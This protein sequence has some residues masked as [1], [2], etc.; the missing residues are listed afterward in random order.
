MMGV[1]F[2]FR[3]DDNA[4]KKQAA[5]QLLEVFHLATSPPS[6]SLL[7]ASWDEEEEELR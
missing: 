7:Q 1:F 6:L 4:D 5:A 2:T 3:A